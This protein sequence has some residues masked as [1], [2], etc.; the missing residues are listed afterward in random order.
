MADA[1]FDRVEFPRDRE[2]LVEIL[3]GDE[4][5]FH[6]HSRLSPADVG[7]MSFATDGV[8]SFWVM[9]G[10][11]RVGLVR[12]MDLDDIG[13]GCP[14][15]DIRVASNHRRQG[16]GTEATRWAVD[17]LFTSHPELHRIEANTRGD[18]VAMQAVLTRVGFALEGRLR[19]AWWSDDGHWY[20]TLVFGVLRDDW[21]AGRR[22]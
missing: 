22:R 6:G 9:D 17:H 10:G 19:Q 3:C 21:N 15:I 20:D 7:E 13:S 1:H 5:P 18:N 4:W 16:L 2:H 11:R 14:L 8:E 12:L